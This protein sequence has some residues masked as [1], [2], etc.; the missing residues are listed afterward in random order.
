[1]S[2]QKQEKYTVYIKNDTNMYHVISKENY[3]LECQPTGIFFNKKEAELVCRLLNEEEN[4]VTIDKN[5]KEEL[6][7][8]FLKTHI[9]QD[10]I[11]LPECKKF[12]SF[13]TIKTMEDRI[14]KYENAIKAIEQLKERE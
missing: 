13:L 8:D 4:R 3:A 6:I 14:K 12:D 10:K 5:I 11:V 2:E 1:M 7:N 9:E